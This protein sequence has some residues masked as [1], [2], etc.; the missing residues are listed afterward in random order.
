MLNEYGQIYFKC[1]IV[2]TLCSTVV[3]IVALITRLQIN[4]KLSAPTHCSTCRNASCISQIILATLHSTTL[5][6][7]PAQR[8]DV[9]SSCS[10]CIECSSKRNCIPAPAIFALVAVTNKCCKLRK[11]VNRLDQQTASLV[12]CWANRREKKRILPWQHLTSL[13]SLWHCGVLWRWPLEWC[14]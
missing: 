11:I 10:N 2:R 4:T 8:S 12:K 7:K 14:N 13:S 6:I 3:L 1:Q 5:Q 9:I